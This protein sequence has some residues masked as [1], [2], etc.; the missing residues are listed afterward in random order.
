MDEQ[1]Q[2]QGSFLTISGHLFPT[3]K[4]VRPA[5]LSS[6][7]CPAPF[8]SRLEATSAVMGVDRGSSLATH[9][10]PAMHRCALDLSGCHFPA[11]A[12][13]ENQR[14]DQSSLN[15]ALC[16]LQDAHERDPGV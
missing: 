12:T 14:R 3:D 11:D 6:L 9:V 1:Q 10:L 13:F 7:H 4:V 15:A 5:T 8:A 16:A 2:G